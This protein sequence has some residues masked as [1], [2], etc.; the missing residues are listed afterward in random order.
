MQVFGKSCKDTSIFNNLLP[1]TL[2]L[3]SIWVIWF[4]FYKF[5]NIYTN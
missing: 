4:Y 1:N 2:K 5:A 3:C